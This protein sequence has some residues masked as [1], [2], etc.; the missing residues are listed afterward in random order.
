MPQKPRRGGSAPE[1]EPVPLVSRS[2]V[3]QAIANPLELG[4][5]LLARPI[6]S[7]DELDG[8]RDDFD[9]WDEYNERLLITWVDPGLG[10]AAVGFPS[11]GG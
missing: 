10:L 8:L 7:E 4:Q 3:D 11:I 1:P 5:Q 2:E 9:T 6:R